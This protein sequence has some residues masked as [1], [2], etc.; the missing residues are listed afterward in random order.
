M[1]R[2]AVSCRRPAWPLLLALATIPP[3][4]EAAVL[5]QLAMPCAAAFSPQVTGMPPFG[6]FH[7]LRW[8]AV[9]HRSWLELALAILGAALFRSVLTA[10]MAYA[11][12]VWPAGRRP[13]LVIWRR[14]FIGTVMLFAVLA[15][16]TLLL[17]GSE[18]V[19]L[20]W[21]VMGGVG[22][23]LVLAVIAH[24]GP[25]S[26]AWWSRFPP[27]STIGW[28]MASVLVFTAAGAVLE[29]APAWTTV[30][31]AGL[32]GVFNVWAWSS[33]VG[34][35]CEPVAAPRRMPVGAIAIGTA[36]VT[37]AALTWVGFRVAQP[38]AAAVRSDPSDDDG[39]F[40]RSATGDRRPRFLV[41]VRR[42]IIDR[43][44]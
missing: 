28:L 4:I 11:A 18:V 5:S 29:A 33:I 14:A 42:A 19:S 20:S 23:F 34:A 8:V 39:R 3:M 7:D 44:W 36:I 17:F 12:G 1:D 10:A 43:S 24:H 16:P 40:G 15:I 26:P 41:V 35:L 31:V 27:A 9:F 30:F 21:I 13:L 22:S 6:A 38:P 32:V 37:M 25:L 2:D